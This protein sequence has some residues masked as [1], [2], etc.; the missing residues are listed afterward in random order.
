MVVEYEVSLSDVVAFNLFH[1]QHSP[2]SRR[3]RLFVQF[4]TPVICLLISFV[5]DFLYT[6]RILTS[7]LLPLIIFS[8]IW[9]PSASVLYWFSIK[10]QSKRM[11]SEG[12]NK[13]TIGKLRLSLTPEAVIEANDFKET[14]TGWKAVEKIVSTDKYVFIYTG[15]VMAHIIP[16]RAF[17]AESEFKEFL[18]TARQYQKE[19][20]TE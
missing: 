18:E 16:R 10:R 14:K 8:L 19:S 1:H 17:S 15:A 4:G 5:L 20:G 13:G 7:S 9:I 3:A 2:T 12:K 6:G 11:Y